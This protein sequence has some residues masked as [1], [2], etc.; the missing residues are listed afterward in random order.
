LAPEHE[1][2]TTPTNTL[3]VPA[4][5]SC[6]EQ[7]TAFVNAELERRLCPVSTLNKIDICLEEIFVNVAHYAYGEEVG[8]AW[9]SY[10]YLPDPPGIRISIA[11]EGTPF[12]PLAKEDPERPKSAEEMRIGGLGIFMT[13]MMSDNLMYE[14]RDGRNITTFDLHWG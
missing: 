5:T 14:Y 13:K 10:E 4:Q 11:D 9:V 6:L 12:D 7:A 1:T 2:A 8:T 3:V